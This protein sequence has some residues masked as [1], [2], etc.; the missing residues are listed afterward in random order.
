MATFE[1]CFTDDEDARRETLS[2]YYKNIDDGKICRS[3]LME[4]GL[5]P[6]Y[7]YIINGHVPVKIKKG[8]S[9]IKG[10]GRLFI[11]DGGIAKAY[12]KTTGIAGY[13]LISSSNYIALAEHM[14]YAPIEPDG[15]QE[16]H[17]PRLQI[18]EK[19][20]HRITV[21]DTDVGVELEAQIRDLRGLIAAYRNGEVDQGGDKI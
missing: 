6:D 20:P 21:R 8:E 7:S 10:G 1:R 18:I 9:P 5:D 3:I 2:P 14:P 12:Q 15:S 13:T 17:A 4:F 11:I 16:F 19:M